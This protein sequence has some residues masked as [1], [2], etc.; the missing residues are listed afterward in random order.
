MGNLQPHQFDTAMKWLKD[1][2]S[3]AACP[4]CNRT[5][6]TAEDG[7]IM[8]SPPPA[9]GMPAD[10]SAMIVVVCNN[11]AYIRLFSAKKMGVK[12]LKPRT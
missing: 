6:W 10:G 12:D 4:V 1:K 7:F 3:E 2:C 8:P 9:G 11:C 5:D